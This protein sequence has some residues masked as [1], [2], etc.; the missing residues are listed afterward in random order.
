MPSCTEGHGRLWE[1][2]GARPSRHPSQLYEA[3]SEGV[4]PLI[5]FFL[6][7]KVNI[8]RS[9]VPILGFMRFIEF[10]REPDSN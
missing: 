3:F 1:C 8:Q 6:I 2:S 5:L 4:L 10:F 7:R 9:S